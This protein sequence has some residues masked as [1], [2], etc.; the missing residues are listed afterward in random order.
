M[1]TGYGKNY[2]MRDKAESNLNYMPE[3]MEDIS[4]FN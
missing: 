1:I 2:N 4:F 3:G